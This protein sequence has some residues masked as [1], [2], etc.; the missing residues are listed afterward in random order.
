MALFDDQMEG[1][2]VSNPHLTDA[3]VPCG[4]VGC[5]P[6]FCGVEMVEE[7][8]Q[9]EEM[10]CIGCDEEPAPYNHDGDY[11]CRHCLDAHHADYDTGNTR[12]GSCRASRGR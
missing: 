11:W 1:L 4:H 3:T 6:S 5:L 9:E 8:L 2:F 7:I 12:C 10:T